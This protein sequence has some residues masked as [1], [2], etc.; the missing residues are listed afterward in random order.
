MAQNYEIRIK[1]HLD[2]SWAD[3]FEGLSIMHQPNGDSLLTM[4]LSDQA[5]LHGLLSRLRDLG[6]ELISV[7]PVEG[8][9]S[10]E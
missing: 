7:N 8:E 3:W 2:Q 10:D 1:G 9:E 4:R 5:A 6:V